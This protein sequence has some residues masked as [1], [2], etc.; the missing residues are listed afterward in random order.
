MNLITDL[1]DVRL[2]VKCI[3]QKRN[4]DGDNMK[5]EGKR[6]YGVFKNTRETIKYLISV[7]IMLYRTHTRFY[8]LS[9]K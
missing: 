5:I 6:M 9:K 1:N 4:M 2:T 8:T 3:F 7:F